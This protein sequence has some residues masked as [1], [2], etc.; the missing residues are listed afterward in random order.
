[1]QAIADQIAKKPDRI[2]AV[3]TFNFDD[4]LEQE[5][6]KRGVE[7][8]PICTSVR[9]DHGMLPII[10]AHGYI[11][12]RGDPPV[13]EIAFTE[14][15]YHALTEGVFHWALTEIVWHLRHRTVLFI[16]LSMSDPNLRRL[17]D[18]SLATGQPPHYQLQ[19]RIKW[20]QRNNSQSCRHWKRLLN[21]GNGISNKGST[22]NLA[23]F[24][25]S[26]KLHCSK[27]TISIPHCFSKWASTPFGWRTTNRSPKCWMRS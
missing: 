8:Q 14:R 6:R 16:G 9:A 21:S 10:H 26:L 12:Q 13:A 23:N 27:L 1:L 3:V 4:L 11:P 24:L 19:K 2:Q 20:H 18:A 25:M 17:L 7:P 22:N 5:L 15:D